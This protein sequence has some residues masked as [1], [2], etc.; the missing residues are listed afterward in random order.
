MVSLNERLLQNQVHEV[1]GAIIGIAHRSLFKTSNESI[2]RKQDKNLRRLLYRWLSDLVINTDEQ[3]RD[4]YRITLIDSKGFFN[5]KIQ[6]AFHHA[7]VCKCNSIQYT[8]F[9]W[10]IIGLKNPTA[11][12][13]CTLNSTMDK[14]NDNIMGWYYYPEYRFVQDYNY[15][16]NAR[17]VCYQ[18]M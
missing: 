1:V 16:P 17:D 2:S 3:T 15:R 9:H 12:P 8:G 7:G 14:F 10:N 5:A 4:N 13:R 6:D 11:R 18:S